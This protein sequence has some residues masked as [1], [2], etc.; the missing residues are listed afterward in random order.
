ML[1]Q[2]FCTKKFSREPQLLMI[3]TIDLNSFVQIQSGQLEALHCLL[4]SFYFLYANVRH[5]LLHHLLDTYSSY[6]EY[7]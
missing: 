4:S 1:N 7:A 3:F 5:G 2:D 6:G